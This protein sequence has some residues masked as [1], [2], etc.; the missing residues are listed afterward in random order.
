VDS[1]SHLSFFLE[2]SFYKV[3]VSKRPN[4]LPEGLA[5]FYDYSYIFSFDVEP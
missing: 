1:A 2:T 4:L 5:P 3:A